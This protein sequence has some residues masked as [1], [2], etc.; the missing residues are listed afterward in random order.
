MTSHLTDQIIRQFAGNKSLPRI[1]IAILDTG[2]DT[3]SQFFNAP[4]RK[5]RLEKWMDFVDNQT[6]PCD[7]DGHGTHVLSLL[8]KIA[9]AANICV[10][11]IA[12]N[13]EDLRDRASEVAKVTLWYTSDNTLYIVTDRIIGNCLGDKS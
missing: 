13:S 7:F 5:N 6:Q 1:R 9:P 3:E 8:M 11:R 12:K 4:A 10:A 2:C